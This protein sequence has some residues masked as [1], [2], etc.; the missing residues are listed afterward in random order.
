MNREFFRLLIFYKYSLKF[1]M[2]CV[3]NI[4]IYTLNVMIQVPITF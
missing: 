2:K 3:R 1:V 4:N